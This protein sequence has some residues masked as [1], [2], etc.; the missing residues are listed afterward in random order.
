M[1]NCSVDKVKAKVSAKVVPSQKTFQ[2][3]ELRTVLK[4]WLPEVFVNKKHFQ[5]CHKNVI[6]HM[7]N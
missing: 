3:M 7:V 6:Y 2:Y 4:L 1:L 5:H